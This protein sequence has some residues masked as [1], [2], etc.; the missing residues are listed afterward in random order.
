MST[1]ETGKGGVAGPLDPEV[2]ARM[3]S[4]FLTA[5]PDFVPLAETAVFAGQGTPEIPKASQ[6]G[7]PAVP[8]N[9]TT[10]QV[11]PS[12][13]QLRALPSNSAIPPA[14]P[15]IPAIPGTAIPEVPG[16]VTETRY[17][18]ISSL[19]F[20][21][22][23]RP[24]FNY[25]A[26]TSLSAVPAFPANNLSSE[27]ELRA[28]ANS[29]DRS[30]TQQVTSSFPASPSPQVL[31]ATVPRE[32]TDFSSGHSFLSEIRQL[33]P[34]DVPGVAELPN[35]NTAPLP[36]LNISS[37]GFDVQAIRRDFPI[38]QERVNG[39]PLI[40]LD[41]AATTQKPQS[42][43]DRI[44]HYYEHENSNIHRAAHELAARATDAYEAAR[45]KVRRFINAPT[46]RE[47]IF[48]RGATEGINLV[49][50]SWGRQHIQKDDEIVITW[51]EHHANIV[52]W[53]MLCAEKGA[54]LRVV[55]VDNTGQ[56]LL[57]EYQRVLNQKTRL[58]A[59]PQVSNALGTVTPA[60]EIIEMAHRYGAKVLMDGAQAVSHMP[61]DVQAFDCDFYVFSGHKMFAP[62]GIGVVYGKSDVLENSPPWQGGGNMIQDVTFEKTTYQPPPG[63]FEAGTG[64]I[65][66]AVGLGAAADYLERIGMA[67][68]LR[69]ERDLLLYATELLQRIPGLHLI[70][71]A[72]EK[73]GVL[74]FVLDE[75]RTEDVGAALN[76]QGIA[77]RAGHHCAQPILRRFGVESTVRPSL[78]FYN[79]CEEIDAL[80]AALWN[81]K[82]GHHSI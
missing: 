66:D 25:P 34:A 20:L 80:A 62:T 26:G 57:D 77:V 3:A 59:F 61:T 74:S 11:I 73:A 48:V 33:V 23:I 58:V 76:R 65:A 63:R 47:I 60:R 53:Q 44:A 18:G 1:S 13:T 10:V 42:V 32:T 71:T 43:I 50:Q 31:G 67:N 22:Q 28:L 5:L 55:P 54:K 19:S 30:S 9:L 51:L 35:A 40:W 64:N 68:I 2:L 41:N 79:T 70:G 39:K 81:L 75:Y 15:Q 82:L 27:T 12:E 36:D 69:Y 6:S 24:I 72:K 37:A 49:A 29:F 21:N 38:L 46:T 52:P 14:Q 17:G 8:V 78:A 56:L 4:E 16:G 7:P 45:E